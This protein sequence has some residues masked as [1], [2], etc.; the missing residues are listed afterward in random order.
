[1]QLDMLGVKYYIFFSVYKLDGS[2]MVVTFT[3]KC[4]FYF[5]LTGKQIT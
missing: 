5:K 2:F 1:M 4:C 3:S